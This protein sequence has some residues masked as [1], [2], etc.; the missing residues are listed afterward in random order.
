MADRRRLVERTKASDAA[1][2]R[3]K[4]AAQAAGS[5]PTS[6]TAATPRESS[7]VARGRQAEESKLHLPDPSWAQRS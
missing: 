3:G 2:G 7:L 1:A 6:P 4:G 5:L